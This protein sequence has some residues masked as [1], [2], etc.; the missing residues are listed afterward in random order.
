VT[1]CKYLNN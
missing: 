1:S